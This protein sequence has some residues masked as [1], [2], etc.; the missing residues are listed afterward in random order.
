MLVLAPRARGRHDR[1]TARRR[2]RAQLDMA[3]LTAT[4]AL[5]FD[6]L[7]RGRAAPASRGRRPTRLPA[8][9]SPGTSRRSATKSVPRRRR[10]P[11]GRGRRDERPGTD[12]ITGAPDTAPTV[13][14]R[15]RVPARIPLLG[16]AGLGPPSSSPSPARRRRGADDERL[17]D[18]QPDSR[19]SRSCRS[20]SG[21]RRRR[22]PARRSRSA[23]RRHAVA[24]ADVASATQRQRDDPFDPGGRGPG[25]LRAFRPRRARTMTRRSSTPFVNGTDSSAYLSVPGFLQ[26]QKARRQ[27]V[28]PDGPASRQ[29]HGRRAD[30]DSATVHVRLHRGRLRH[31]PRHRATPLECRRTTR[32]RHAPGDRAC[33]SRPAGSSTASRPSTHEA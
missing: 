5:D 32:F 15:I 8:S 30:G 12:P 22:D 26:G 13:S 6:A 27:G 7:A 10:S 29:P 31:R 3:A 19:S 2:I 14:I 9:T 21:S 33:A 28:G 11:R 18:S 25:L 1:R 16:L 4:Q 20:C 17:A 23:C 24:E